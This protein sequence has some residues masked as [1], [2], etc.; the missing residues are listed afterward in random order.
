MN[1]VLLFGATDSVWEYGRVSD[2]LMYV[3]RLLL[4]AAILHYVDD[5]HGIEPEGTARFCIRR[6]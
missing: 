6:L 5:F 1:H 4:S 3:G 2:F